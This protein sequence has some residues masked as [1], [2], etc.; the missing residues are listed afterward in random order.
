MADMTYD[1]VIVGGSLGGVSAALSAANVSQAVDIC[2]L[3]A[4]AWLGGQFTAQGVTKPDEN[5]YIETVGSTQTY[6]AFR[7]NVR[8]FYRNNYR[9]SA[10]GSAQPE[11]DPGGGYPG[12]TMEP[13]VGHQVLSQSLAALPNVHVRLNN[14]VTGVEMNGDAI[15]SVTAVDSTG[16]S[17]RYL[18]TYFLDAT[19]LGDLLPQCGQEG[20]DWVIGAESQADTGEPDAPPEAH[21]EWIQPITLPFAIEHRPAGEDNTI[22]KPAD[23]DQLKQEQNYS[24]LDGYI[25]TMFVPGK[26]MWS[27]RSV[28]AAA[29]FADPAYPYDITMVNMAGNDYQAKTTPNA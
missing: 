28:I 2:L 9:L 21:P 7:H 17:T 6:R 12:F 27:Y 1:V 22:P 23:Y 10:Q 20:A 3:E 4:T 16:T 13:L 19:D 25:S 29:N 24:I 15:T 8:A 14:A 5:Q 18:A 26:D 11:F